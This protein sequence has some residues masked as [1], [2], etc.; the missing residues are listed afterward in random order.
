MRRRPVVLERCGI[1]GELEQVGADAAEPEQHRS[2]GRRPVAEHPQAPPASLD[3]VGTQRAGR[4]PGP[5]VE[6]GQPGAVGQTGIGLAASRPAT[7]AS[8]G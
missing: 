8:I 5:A 7:P 1:D 6:R 2:L 4:L 3:E